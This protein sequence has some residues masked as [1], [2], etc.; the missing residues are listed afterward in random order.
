MPTNAQLCASMSLKALKIES[1]AF[2]FCC[3]IGDVL[4]TDHHHTSRGGG[5]MADTLIGLRLGATV[6]KP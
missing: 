2:N 4:L 1:K 6:Y 5:V 3:F